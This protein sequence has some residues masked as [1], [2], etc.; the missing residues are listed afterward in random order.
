M[1]DSTSFPHPDFNLADIKSKLGKKLG[2]SS[3]EIV[4]LFGHRTLG[5]FSN[6]ENNKEHRWS[7]NPWVF[8]NNY[9][10]ELTQKNSIY[11]KTPSDLALLEDSNFAEIASNFAQDQNLFFQEFKKAY[12]KISEFGNE[13]LLEEKVNHI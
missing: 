11:L 13:T 12:E 7:Q 9:F 10:I 8:D 2:L 3:T 5:F 4:A 1:A 6:K